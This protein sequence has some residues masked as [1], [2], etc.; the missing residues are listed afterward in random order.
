LAVEIKVSTFGESFGC[1]IKRLNPGQITV[2]SVPLLISLRFHY[3]TAMRAKA[4]RDSP[5]IHS[6]TPSLTKIPILFLVTSLVTSA[7]R[8]LLFVNLDGMITMLENLKEHQGC[9]ELQK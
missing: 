2:N 8:C 6:E 9:F 1:W 7:C 5:K 3:K 4:I